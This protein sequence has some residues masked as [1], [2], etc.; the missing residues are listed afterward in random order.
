MVQLVA[1]T[2]TDPLLWYDEWRLTISHKRLVAGLTTIKFGSFPTSRQK[3]ARK[4]SK[5]MPPCHLHVRPGS[6]SARIVR[7]MVSIHRHFTLYEVLSST[8]LSIIV[9]IR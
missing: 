4:S 8:F 2:V 3:A 1:S 7:A 5:V 6:A 9:A